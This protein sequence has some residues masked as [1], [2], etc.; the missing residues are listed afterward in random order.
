MHKSGNIRDA[1]CLYESIL[2]TESTNAD[3]VGLLALALYQTGDSDNAFKYWTRCLALDSDARTRLRNANNY[4]TAF[5]AP[6]TAS[7]KADA[8]NFELPAWPQEEIP[9]A[10]E[11]GM[12]LSLARGL[13]QFGRKQ[14]VFDL[15]QSFLP[16]VSKDLD[17]LGKS[18][19]VLWEAGYVKW[20]DQY[21]S[22]AFSPEQ[23][24]DGQLLLLRA[25][26]ASAAKRI[27]ESVACVSRAVDVI[28]VHVTARA[29]SQKFLIGVLNR[30]PTR[31]ET[32]LT[33]Q[34]FHFTENT[35]AS[36]ASR[37][38]DKYRFLSI[39]PEAV[40][41]RSALAAQPSPDFIINNWVN[42]EVLSTPGTLSF[43]SAF[44]DS[45]EQAV[46]NHPVSAATTTR[47]RNSENLKG[48]PNLVVPH[49]LRFMNQP[50]DPSSIVRLIKNDVG[51]PVIVRD[52]F[53][54][55]GKQASKLDTPDQLFEHLRSI[56]ALTLEAQARARLDP[57]RCG[58]V[59]SGLDDF[60]HP[61]LGLGLAP[62]AGR[63][64]RL[65]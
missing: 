22:E 45:L 18:L 27:E 51:F 63:E 25:A 3:V 64:R 38:S 12:V 11:K 47:Q 10:A 56:P 33:P 15:L 61:Q 14:Q 2:E 54:Q 24:T 13:N 58:G 28:P 8:I 48:I 37:F 65:S 44:A 53:H 20:V 16:R 55:M 7:N 49:V 62:R 42:A 26:T 40:T 35:P 9:E 4:L 34:E 60:R 36:L 59:P 41:V 52:P 31:V 39:L 32:P 19:R 6:T 29:E 43:I 17:V 5:L 50:D 23:D 21:L 1:V 57:G 46:L 30:A